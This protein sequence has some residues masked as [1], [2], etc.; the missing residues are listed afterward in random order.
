MIY[1]ILWVNFK[2]GRKELL[3][4]E[5][6][7]GL[8][9]ENWAYFINHRSFHDYDFFHQLLAQNPGP[10]LDV[11]CGT[12]R[13]LVPLLKAG[14]EV[15]G[16]DI[17]PDLLAICRKNA[18]HEG[19]K[20]RLFQQ[21]MQE[22]NLPH[23]YQ[24]VLVPCDAFYLVVDRSEAIETLDRFYNHLEPGGLLAFTLPSPFE[25]D[26]PD[27]NNG[28]FAEGWTHSSQFDRPDGSQIEEAILVE[29]F[30]RIEQI[31]TGQVRFRVLEAGKVV[32]EEIYPWNGRHYFRNEVLVMLEN[33]GFID[34]SV[35]GDFTSDPYSIDH[36]QMTFVAR[37]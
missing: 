30:D 11:G 15:D 34:I 1:P 33:A 22:L 23:I 6:W 20:P 37:K 29:Q 10:A 25:E 35:Y 4:R 32:Q 12:G 18:E 3:Q 24:S 2:A 5:L 27:W 19:L 26:G 14:F 31:I 9:A 8:E 17:S 36:T 7:I 16:V 28:S 21:A 13:L